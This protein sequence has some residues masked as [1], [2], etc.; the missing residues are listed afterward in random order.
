MDP[1]LIQK[2][3]NGEVHIADE[4][5]GQTIEV[6]QKENK[7]KAVDNG[8]NDV[9]KGPIDKGQWIRVKKLG[10]S[11]GTASTSN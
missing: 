11:G 10:T 6:G 5:M 4:R 7:K 3:V 8:N 9:V 1:R 2:H